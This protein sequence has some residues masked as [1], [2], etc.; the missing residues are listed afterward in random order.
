MH[1]KWARYVLNIFS[2]IEDKLQQFKEIFY[3]FFLIYESLKI[4]NMNKL[5]IVKGLKYIRLLVTL[6]RKYI[7]IFE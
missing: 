2:V 6:F 5:L 4:N 3:F 1:V 7:K